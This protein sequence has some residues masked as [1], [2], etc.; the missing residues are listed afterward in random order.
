MKKI[1]FILF[2]LIAGT[3]F[4]QNTTSASADVNAVI[5]SP[6]SITS[7]RALNF[8]TIA[9]ETSGGNVRIAHDAIGTRTFSNSG[10]R[11]STSLETPTSAIFEITAPA[12]YTY[13]ISIPNTTLS[14]GD[15]EI[16]VSFTH[17]QTGTGNEGGVT[18][19]LY[20]GGLLDVA[21]N[22]DSGTYEGVVTVTVAYE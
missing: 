7:T 13:G 16:P 19:M 8:G 6:I 3:A 18:D 1:T 10:M 22:E 5:V 2:A 17:S 20:V 14:F 21:G 15:F 11:V 12:G 4:G 9:Q